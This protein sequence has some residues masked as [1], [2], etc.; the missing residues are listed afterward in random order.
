MHPKRIHLDRVDSTNS[1]ISGL[2]RSGRGQE[3]LVVTADFQEAGRGQGDR[4]WISQPGENLLM[5]VLL[6]PAFLSAS[7]QFHLSRIASL[8]VVDTLKGFDLDPYVKWPNDILV[9][10]KKIAGILIENG[11]TGKKLSHSIIGTGL[12]LNQE[13]FPLFPFPATSLVMEGWQRI[14]P[15]E[16]SDRLLESLGARYSQLESGLT[17]MLEKEY[18]DHLYLM[19]RPGKFISG[20]VHFTGIIRGVDD[21]GQLVVEQNGKTEVFAFQHI[22]YVMPG[23]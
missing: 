22:Q 5:S 18:L 7:S 16:V 2:L 19:D 13:Q 14:R 9:N 20:G 15:R 21:S 23:D 11:I 4:G 1:Y 17:H 10:G 6:F 8:A 3:E 12:N